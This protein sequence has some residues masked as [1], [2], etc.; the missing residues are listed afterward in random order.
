MLHTLVVL[1]VGWGGV[2]VGGWWVCESSHP[3]NAVRTGL[4]LVGG[5]GGMCG[6]VIIYMSQ[7][8][9]QGDD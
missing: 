9:I 1:W 4:R 2:G 5:C 6:Y 3:Y 7:K 8:A